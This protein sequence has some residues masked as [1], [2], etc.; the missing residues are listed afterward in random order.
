[1]KPEYKNLPK[2]LKRDVTVPN[3][4]I[5]NNEA[6]KGSYTKHISKNKRH[7]YNFFTT[8]Q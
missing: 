7:D 5:C 6:Q 3:H 1:M 4:D 2:S 8:A